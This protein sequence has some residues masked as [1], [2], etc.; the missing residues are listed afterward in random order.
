MKGEEEGLETETE[1]GKTPPVRLQKGTELE[2]Q[3]RTILNRFKW[4]KGSG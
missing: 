4:S 1:K 2:W 3:E